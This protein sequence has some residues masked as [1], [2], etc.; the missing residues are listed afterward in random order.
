VASIKIHPFTCERVIAS[1]ISPLLQILVEPVP[2]FI[3]LARKELEPTHFS[4]LM[5]HIG[6]FTGSIG[7]DVCGSIWSDFPDLAPEG[8]AGSGAGFQKESKGGD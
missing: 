4:A 6:A 3:P 8:W 2:E 5:R 1:M 7:R